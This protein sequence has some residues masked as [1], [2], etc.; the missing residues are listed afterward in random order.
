[1]IA[2]EEALDAAESEYRKFNDDPRQWMAYE[3]LDKRGMRHLNIQSGHFEHRDALL[4]NIEVRRTELRSL[5]A[6][7]VEGV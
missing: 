4:Q 7:F 5:R 2:A 3:S 1:L 6:A